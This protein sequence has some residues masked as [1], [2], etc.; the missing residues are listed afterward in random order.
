MS[1]V[2]N[3]CQGHGCVSQGWMRVSLVITG[4]MGLLYAAWTIFWPDLWFTWAG[5]TE[6]TYKEMW[7]TVGMLNGVLGIGLLLA[8]SNP[9]HHWL[10]VLTA[11]IAKVC[12]TV[13]F[14]WAVYDGVFPLK[15]G[16]IILINDVLFIP[17]L[18]LVLWR[19]AQTYAGRPQIRDNAYSLEEAL[20]NYTL[21]SEASLYELSFERPVV[22]VF[23]RHFGCTF[24]RQ[25]LRKLESLQ[26]SA[27]ANDAK[28]VLVHMLQRGE[29]NMYL[30]N[31]SVARISDPYCE[32]YRTFGLGKGGVL[33]LFGPKV[34]FHGVLAL[35]K[36]CGV[37]H[38]AGDGLQLPGAFVLKDG[39][40]ISSQRAKTAADLPE[41]EKLFVTSANITL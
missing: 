22:I 32:L 18:L 36:G 28:L 38:L 23:L 25:L 12:A 13:G 34:I 9:I 26:E 29:E 15:A 7:M 1:K 14:L 20:K 37:G 3:Q 33:E 24:T 11:T 39:E 30:E 8:A 35:V 41:V 2:Q 31:E 40:I 16:W 27:E 21:G 4:V 5:M 17:P 19:T 10:N 6:S